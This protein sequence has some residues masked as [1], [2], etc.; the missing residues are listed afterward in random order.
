MAWQ[1]QC[2]LWMPLKDSRGVEHR[3]WGLLSWK[4]L[5][6]PLP[7]QVTSWSAPLTVTILCLDSDFWAPFQGAESVADPPMMVLCASHVQ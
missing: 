2:A 4:N 7:G 3:V 5:I 6:C 1:F